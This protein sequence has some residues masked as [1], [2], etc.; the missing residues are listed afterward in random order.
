MGRRSWLEQIAGRTVLLHLKDADSIEGILLGVYDD[1]VL[2]KRARMLK[3]SGEGTELS[4][5]TF[6]ARGQIVL[7]QHG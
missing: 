5:E 6:V 4:G 3:G 1:G 2:L 7:A